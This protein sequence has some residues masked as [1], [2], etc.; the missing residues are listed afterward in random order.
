MRRREFSWLVKALRV[1]CCASDSLIFLSGDIENGGVTIIIIMIRR[2]FIE[3]YLIIRCFPYLDAV[4][5]IK[6]H[7]HPKSPIITRISFQF[8]K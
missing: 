6:T 7:N 8:H 4:P 2:S 5:L 3:I 1:S